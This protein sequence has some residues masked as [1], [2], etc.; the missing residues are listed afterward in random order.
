MC[1]LKPKCEN[2]LELEVVEV[3]ARTGI[4]CAIVVQNLGFIPKGLS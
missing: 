1:K 2:V 4:K 3:S